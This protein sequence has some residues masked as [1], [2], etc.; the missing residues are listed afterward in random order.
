VQITMAE[1][2][3]VEDRGHFY[4][5]V[6]AV[7]DV[8]VNHLMQVLGAAA[9]EPPSSPRALKD[10]LYAVFA[11]MPGADP[12]D[13]VRG[14]Y[15]GYRET[16]GV[17]P[18]SKTET[19]A[20]M[21][22]DID[23]WR[24]E[25][26]PFYIRTGKHLPITQTELR[27]VFRRP[28]QLFF[29]ADRSRRPEPGQLVVRLDPST[30][31][32]LLV[33]AQPPDSP[34]AEQFSLDLEFSRQGGEGPTPYEV[35]LGAAMRGDSTRFTRQD[36]VEETWRILQPLLDVDSEP[37]VYAKGSWGPPEAERLVAHH[38]GWHGPWAGS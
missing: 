4:D 24:W 1:D 35:L 31:V 27:L 2:F 14:Q 32:R 23:N 28:P 19:Y 38:G 10:S 5:P 34:K 21:R 18:G 29:H 15:A 13:Y 36:S 37:S 26:V 3:G 7:R 22:L 8:V 6:G 30:G 17:A 33:E 12:A 11:A 20:A 9:M 16:P 25:G